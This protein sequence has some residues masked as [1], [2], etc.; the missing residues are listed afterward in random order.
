[1]RL[2]SYKGA[3][4]PTHMG[5]CGNVSGSVKQL[6]NPSSTS[7]PVSGCQCVHYLR[8][9]YVRAETTIDF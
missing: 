3:S 9:K 8:S 6:A 5:E 1:M 4:N 7:D 2:A